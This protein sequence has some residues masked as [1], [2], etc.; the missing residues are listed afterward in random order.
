MTKIM[1]FPE[2]TATPRY[3][4]I[5]GDKQSFGATA[6]EALDALNAQLHEDNSAKLVV[7]QPPGPDEY[8][9]KEQQDRLAELF[10][11]WRLARDNNQTLADEE[12][13][14]LDALIHAELA[15]SARRTQALL[16]R[17]TP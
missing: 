4:A 3:H 14:E 11:R 2:R 7:I 5:A 16:R 15:A 1:I 13:A 6:G 12:Q 10:T 8:F 17:A 9:S